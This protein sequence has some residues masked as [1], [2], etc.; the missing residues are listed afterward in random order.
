MLV[1]YT[2]LNG[3]SLRER[4]REACSND[5]VIAYLLMCSK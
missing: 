3:E 5:D 1:V 2:C 4:K